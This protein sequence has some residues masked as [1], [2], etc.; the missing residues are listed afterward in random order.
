MGVEGDYRRG[1]ARVEEE[2]G[3]LL[4]DG[5]VEPVLARVEAGEVGEDLVVVARLVED[6][7][8]LG[9]LRALSLGLREALGLIQ[10]IAFK[11]HGETK[12]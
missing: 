12:M 9:V 10:I 11:Y 5:L 2:V 8:T 4:D 6:Q 1:K 7:H 3:D